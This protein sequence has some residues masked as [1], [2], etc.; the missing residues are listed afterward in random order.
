MVIY[1]HARECTHLCEKRR[2]LQHHVLPLRHPL[3]LRGR[4][5]AARARGVQPPAAWAAC[6]H[7]AASGTHSSAR[8]H[9]ASQGAPCAPA[10]T[11]ARPQL[12]Q[13]P[14][15]YKV[16]ASTPPSLDDL[17]VLLQAQVHDARSVHKHLVVGVGHGH[18]RQAQPLARA[19]LH[20]PRLAL[21]RVLCVCARARAR[22]RR[23]G[24][25]VVCRAL[26][27]AL[28]RGQE[29]ARGRGGSAVTRMVRLRA[30]HSGG[31]RCAAGARRR[32]GGLQ[33]RPPFRLMLAI[34]SICFAAS[35]SSFDLALLPASALPGSPGSGCFDV[36]KPAA[37]PGRGH[38]ARQHGACMW[39]HAWLAAHPGTLQQRRRRWAKQ[40]AGTHMGR[41]WP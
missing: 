21:L 18:G 7:A 14:E 35:S 25:L 34:F 36:A 13:V 3:Q 31:H 19:V 1:T 6:T 16:C 40:G 22:G 17:L 37:G 38:G 26:L 30:R 29:A 11:A 28:G 2:V 24:G 32:W 20:A 10:G 27:M 4:H 41:A 12:Q 15:G 39:G 5:R 23:A 33:H 8:G 9:R